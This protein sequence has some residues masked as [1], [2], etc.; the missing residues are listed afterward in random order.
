M[1]SPQTRIILPT[2]AT[3][4]SNPLAATTPTAIAHDTVV[5]TNREGEPPEYREIKTTEQI[6][7]PTLLEKVPPTKMTTKTTTTTTVEEVPTVSTS[8][9]T[10]TTT[11]KEVP[12]AP[13]SK[14]TTTVQETPA[15]TDYVLKQADEF[16]PI[17]VVSDTTPVNSAN[18]QIVGTTSTGSLTTPGKIVGDLEP[19][20]SEHHVTT[21]AEPVT[22][23]AIKTVT[24]ETKE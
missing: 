2:N 21:V 18:N 5:Q 14:V 12:T 3:S 13:T 8:K 24:K 11:V 4:V 6:L 17:A 7:E 15:S 23:K 20:V 10:T 19:I 16:K 1:N 9:E 22:K